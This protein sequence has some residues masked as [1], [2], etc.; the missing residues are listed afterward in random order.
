MGPPP[1]GYGPLGPRIDWASRGTFAV[2]ASELNCEGNQASRSAILALN[3]SRLCARNCLA[4]GN[5]CGSPPGP[6]GVC[7]TVLAP[8]LNC[9]Q[10]LAG[11]K[12]TRSPLVLLVWAGSGD[13]G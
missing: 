1:L 10:G 3:A 6:S 2:L 9:C 5:G 7:Y 4:V 12:A 11:G 8:E 13:S